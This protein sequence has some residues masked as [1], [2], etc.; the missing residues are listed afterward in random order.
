[1]LEDTEVSTEELAAKFG[2]EV[3]ALVEAVTKIALAA[4]KHRDVPEQKAISSEYQM[5]L[6][7]FVARDP[8]AMIVKLADR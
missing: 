4:K 7:A 5:R 3:C 1:M 2:D 8:R 6:F